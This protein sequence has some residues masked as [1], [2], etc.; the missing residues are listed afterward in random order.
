MNPCV[1]SVWAEH[2][3]ALALRICITS[4]TLHYRCQIHAMI[5]TVYE[6]KAAHLNEYI[7]Q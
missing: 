5:A 2:L 1:Q 3:E 4:A 7:I 6:T